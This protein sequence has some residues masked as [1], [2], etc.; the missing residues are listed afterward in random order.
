MFPEGLGKTKLTVSRGVR[1][2]VFCYTS[3]LKSR[4]KKTYLTLVG[5]QICLDFEEHVL[6]TCEPKVQ[7]VSL[8]I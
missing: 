2:E 1:H 3:Q 5:S 7:V 6:I 8:G 4:K